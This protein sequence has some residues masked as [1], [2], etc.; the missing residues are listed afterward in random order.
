MCMILVITAF[1]SY[2]GKFV[3]NNEASVLPIDSSSQQQ[4]TKE[5][6]SYIPIA[7]PISALGR[8]RKKIPKPWRFNWSKL[9][10]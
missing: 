8:P 5:H 1:Y 3:N 7:A 10:A 2:E 9:N 4:T 6:E